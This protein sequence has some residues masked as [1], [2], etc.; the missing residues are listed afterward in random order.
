M[1]SSALVADG[2]LGLLTLKRWI[3]RMFAA[4]CSFERLLYLFVVYLTHAVGAWT[5]L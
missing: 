1:S 5:S 2:R 3:S 4:L